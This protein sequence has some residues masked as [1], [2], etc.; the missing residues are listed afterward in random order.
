MGWACQQFGGAFLH[1]VEQG[2]V[3][4]ALP[5]GSAFAALGQMVG[6]GMV[7]QGAQ[8]AVDDGRGRVVHDDDC[9]CGATLGR[10]TR[11]IGGPREPLPVLDR[12]GF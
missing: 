2:C 8:A 4:I 6:Y 9:E 5:K 1:F 11:R 3:H 10:G 12:A 7:G